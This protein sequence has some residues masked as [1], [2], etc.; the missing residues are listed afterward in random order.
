M[1]IY[2]FFVVVR[3]INKR[4]NAFIYINIQAKKRAFNTCK[5]NEKYYLKTKNMCDSFEWKRR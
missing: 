2:S 3:K 4:L 1:N 5:I